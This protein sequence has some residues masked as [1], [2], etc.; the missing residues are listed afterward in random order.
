MVSSSVHEL[1][2][3]DKWLKLCELSFHMYYV[4]ITAYYLV[5]FIGPILLLRWLSWTNWIH[6]KSSA[7]TTHDGWRKVTAVSS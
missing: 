7:V 1:V 3:E 2:V 5:H 6:L 4:V